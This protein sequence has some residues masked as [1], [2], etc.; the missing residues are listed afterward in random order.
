MSKICIICRNEQEKESFNSEHII[1]ATI[2][3]CL[4]IDSVCVK[5]NGILGRT[6]NT[7]FLAA[8]IIAYYRQKLGLH[9]KDDRTG[10]RRIA[11]PLKKAQLE[12]K[13]VNADDY[14]IVFKEGAAYSEIVPKI[15]RTETDTGMRFEI[16][17]SVNDMENIK[18]KVFEK[19]K[20]DE[21]D[22]EVLNT[23]E[24][25]NPPMQAR[26]RN[27]NRPIHI[28][29]IKMAY[30]FAVTVIPEYFNDNN[31][32]LI[33][34]FLY[35]SANVDLINIR[36]ESASEI[37]QLIDNELKALYELPL[38]VQVISLKQVKEIGLVCFVKI[39]DMVIPYRMSDAQ[40][41]SNDNRDI[42]ILND[43]LQNCFQ[44]Q[45]NLRWKD[46]GLNVDLKGL[47]K[48]KRAVI[49][50]D[51]SN[52][53]HSICQELDYI[54]LFDRLGEVITSNLAESIPQAFFHFKAIDFVNRKTL[55]N[56]TFPPNEVFVRYI[57]TNTL[58]PL[59]GFKA[60]YHLIR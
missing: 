55:L 51:L 42:T 32:K 33:S 13:G 39:F 54:S 9:R 50:N 53:Y 12:G 5:C 44:F 35:N 37:I 24:S 58:L 29:G 31:A 4:E 41:F 8:P 18:R 40:Y 47:S 45:I 22:I 16:T 15:V 59:N 7:P 57:P 30:E 27:D 43:S 17:A 6:I 20:I 60:E 49:I 21:A 3:G 14:Y 25:A 26:I 11:N 1:L 48:S 56:V 36:I 28:E 38:H 23:R 46:I 10:L 2:G 52:G 19:Y 34:E